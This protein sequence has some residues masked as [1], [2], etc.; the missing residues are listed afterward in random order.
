MSC[1]TRSRAVSLPCLCCRD[2]FSGPPPSRSRASS[3]RV[4]AL[5]S[6]SREVTLP[7]RA[8]LRA[9][10]EPVLDVLH[11]VGGGSAGAKELSDALRLQYLHVFLGDDAAAGHEDVA[12]PL[13][14]QQ[15]DDAREERHV[16]AGEDREA[17][18]VDVLLHRRAR[19][20]LRRLVEA[21]VDDLHAGIT[22]RG[23]DDLRAAVVAVET[24]LGDEHSNGA[25][26]SLNLT[27]GTGAGNYG[28]PDTACVSAAI[29]L[30]ALLQ[31]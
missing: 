5:S 16:R 12:A 8:A 2:A 3:S 9:V 23:G 20:H 28:A 19:D 6:R 7:A 10:S 29:S 31:R 11:E 24:G 14:L 13:G 26:H 25:C 30:E 4:A 15:L 1:V 21:G 17:D 27:A 18:D 22:Q